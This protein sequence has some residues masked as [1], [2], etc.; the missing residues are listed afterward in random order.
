[1]TKEKR[2]Q[3]VN[4]RHDLVVILRHLINASCGDFETLS[5]NLERLIDTLEQSNVYSKILLMNDSQ[6]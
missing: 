2:E 1:M 5:H 6:Q 3:L 4:Y